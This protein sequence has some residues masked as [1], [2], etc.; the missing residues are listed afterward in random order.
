MAK[1]YLFDW[2]D[3]LMVDFPEQNGKMCDWVYVEAV[4]GAKEALDCLSQSS[5][6]YIAT[7]AAESSESEIKL[8]FERVGLSEFISGYFCKTRLGIPKGTPDFYNAIVNELGVEPQ[9]ITMIG[10]TFENDISPAL[11]AGLYAVW[12][13]SDNNNH[14]HEKKLRK[15]SS[16]HELCI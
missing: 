1:V 11:K 2:G 3:T 10:D 6:I 7:N 4:D 5:K 15:I 16:L 8:A 13:S 14:K 9:D 12:F